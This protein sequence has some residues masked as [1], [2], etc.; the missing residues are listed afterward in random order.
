LR[1]TEE[2]VKFA[3]A[4]DDFK[5]RISGEVI[6][7]ADNCCVID[8]GLRAAGSADILPA[9]CASGDYVT[10]MISIELPLSIARVPR[11]ILAALRHKWL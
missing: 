9:G 5:Y 7:V 3:T 1:V 8:F 2:R 11:E 6:H 10:G 4:V